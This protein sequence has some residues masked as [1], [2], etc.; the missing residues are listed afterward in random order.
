M[1]S[2]DPTVIAEGMNAGEKLQ[3]SLLSFPPATTT[4]TPA[5]V[6]ASTAVC[7]P[8]FVPGPPKLMLATFGR[9]EF[10][11]TQSNP[12]VIQEYWP[13]PWSLKTFTLR[14]VAPGA[15]PYCVPPTV[16]AQ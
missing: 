9:A 4:D 1:E 7:N 5:R 11:A 2:V 10:L 3:E 6:A 8:E 14:I 13:L 16:P 15:T 12:P